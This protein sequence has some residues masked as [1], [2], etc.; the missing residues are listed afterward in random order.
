MK[1]RWEFFV[2]ISHL[3][4]K[5]EIMTKYRAKKKKNPIGKE[6]ASHDNQWSSV[7]QIPLSSPFSNHPF[8]PNHGQVCNLNLKIHRELWILL[9]SF[10]HSEVTCR[11]LHK[12]PVK[13]EGIRPDDH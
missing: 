2:L 11:N 9:I 4:C 1:S 12:E 6:I 13:S 7:F 10:L 3:F 5:S 8:H